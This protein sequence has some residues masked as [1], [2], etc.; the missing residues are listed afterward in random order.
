MKSRSAK[1]IQIEPSGILRAP[2]D[3]RLTGQSLPQSLLG[4]W[5][6][7]YFP[8]NTLSTWSPWSGIAMKLQAF[9]WKTAQD[10]SRTFVVDAPTRHD[11]AF[12]SLRQAT[13]ERP[14]VPPY[15]S[16]NSVRRTG[17]S[18]RDLQ[19]GIT[20]ARAAADQI[21]VCSEISSASSTSIPRY[22]TVD[23]SFECPRSN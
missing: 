3:W 21:S 1:G 15:Q 5:V 12:R 20:T 14:Q 9:A 23:S 13:L 18:K 2:V 7:I 10:W 19:R 8:D 4:G 22:L 6:L 11:A 16:I 17:P